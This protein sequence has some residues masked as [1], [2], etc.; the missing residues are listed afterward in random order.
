MI[1]LVDCTLRDGGHVNKSN[2]GEKIIH[3]IVNNLLASNVDIIEL[4]FLKDEPYQEGIAVFN[5]IND[6]KKY[7]KQSSTTQYALLVQ[8]DQ[9]DINKLED[10]DGSIEHIRVSFHCYDLTE[11]LEYCKKIVQKG[12]KC[13]VNPIN[14]QGYSDKE[15][16]EILQ[17]VNEINPYTFTIVDTFGAMTEKDLNRIVAIVDN[18]LKSGINIGL[19]LHE[20]LGLSFS[21]AQFFTKIKPETR[22]ISIDASLN[23]MGR[24]P[25]NLSIELIMD[26][27][28]RTYNTNYDLNPIYDIIDD[29]I[30]PI[31]KNNPWGYSLPYALS[32]QHRLHRT[33]AEFLVSKMKLKT[34]D[35]QNI[36]SSIS[37]A[38]K[39]TYNKNYI[40]DLYINYLCNEIDDSDS[41]KKLKNE[42]N[43]N[44]KILL[45]A[46][47]NSLNTYKDEII[48]FINKDK[49]II[50]STN[51]SLNELGLYA[52][53]IFLSNIQRYEQ[54]NNIK[55]KLIITSNLVDEVQEAHI[56]LNL[57]NLIFN[58]QNY[59]CDN[60]LLLLLKLLQDF[61]F[62]D[63][64]IAGFDGFDEHEKNYFNK[65]MIPAFDK[66]SAK[67][68]DNELVKEI[69]KKYFYNLNIISL[70]P[71]F[72]FDKQNSL[73]EVQNV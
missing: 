24:V 73:N 61:N 57:R 34:K 15:L 18:N 52:D 64:Y 1:K 43:N 71:S 63:I 58:K 20:N 50:I 26:Y 41:Q 69:L 21:L 55:E 19:H 67:F 27:M 6:A 9:Y 11:G 40:Q 32:A 65:A 54:L 12:Y 59:K 56:I 33:Y 72:Y 70:T 66:I 17:T 48:E 30:L 45:I 42:L 39:A 46:P 4:G 7:M 35:I 38:E 8:E 44:N 3:K 49:P 25:G 10:C 36:L 13:H 62:K 53:Y 68:N 14:L 47:G 29:Y 51:F 2:F 31:K 60:A 16:I 28:N 5:C 37:P 23:G 22:D